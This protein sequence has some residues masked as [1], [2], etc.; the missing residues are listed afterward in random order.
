MWLILGFCALGFLI[1][2]L[3]G[4]TSES[5]VTPLVGLLFA[6]VGTSI[7]AVLHK[8][9]IDDRRLAGKAVLALA[10]CCLIGVYVGIIVTENRWLSPKA[11]RNTPAISTSTVPS[12][13][14]QE[15][16]ERGKDVSA[17]TKYLAD[18]PLSPPDEIDFQLFH[19]NLTLHE[20][21]L[22]MYNLA[23]SQHQQTDRKQK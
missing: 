10:S 11:R 21:Y 23:R 18:R 13:G 20:A 19:G 1:G 17:N 12:P 6:F 4:M 14:N 22:Q 16:S 3:T 7:L 15:P 9:N 8:L 5:V 2:N